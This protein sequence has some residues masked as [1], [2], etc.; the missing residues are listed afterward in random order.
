MG[1]TDMNFLSVLSERRAGGEH[2]EMTGTKS[3]ES[4]G[5]LKADRR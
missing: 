3:G 1:A 4:W 2:S 5:N